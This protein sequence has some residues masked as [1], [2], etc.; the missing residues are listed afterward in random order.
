MQRKWPKTITCVSIALI[1]LL[2]VIVA[3]IQAQ[4]PIEIRKDWNLDMDVRM[5]WGHNARYRILS[6]LPSFWMLKGKFP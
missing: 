1:N 5:E 4:V 2:F 3:L 6:A